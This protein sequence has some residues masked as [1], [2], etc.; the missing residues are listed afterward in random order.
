VRRASRDDLSEIV[1]G[2]ELLI[3]QR[4]SYE[5]ALRDHFPRLLSAYNGDRSRVFSFDAIDAAYV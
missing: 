5:D 3:E 2:A 1:Q 4:L